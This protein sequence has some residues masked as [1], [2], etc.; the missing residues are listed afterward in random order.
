M[1]GKLVSYF[2]NNAANTCL[3][4]LKIS[5][6][7]GIWHFFQSRAF[8]HTAIFTQVASAPLN[9]NTLKQ[10]NALFDQIYIIRGSAWLPDADFFWIS[11]WYLKLPCYFNQ[12]LSIYKNL[13]TFVNKIA[14]SVLI[15][16]F[17]WRTS[18]KW[19]N[20]ILSLGTF[21]KKLSNSLTDFVC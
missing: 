1:R 14:K 19:N 13:K 20:Y 11:H 15:L 16:P 17:Y 3:Y 7:I 5:E 18:L 4:E 6:N 9:R 10:W 2:L 21:N 12:V 8:F